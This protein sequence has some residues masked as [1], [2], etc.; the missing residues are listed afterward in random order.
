LTTQSASVTEP[1]E[2]VAAHVSP[3]AL[4]SRL[5]GGMIWLAATKVLG[6][7]INWIITI[8][9]LR[10]LSPQ[11]YGLMGLA[12]LFT[13]F[14]LL[15][16]EF[17]FG[18]AIV[19]DAKLDGRQ[20]ANLRYAIFL[21]NFTLFVLTLLG[22]PLVA[23]YFNEPS[24]VA[25]VRALSAMFVIN[26]VGA[27]SMFMLQREMAFRKK[28]QAEIV[29]SLAGGVMTLLGAL[30]GFGVWSLVIGYLLQQLAT[31]ALYVVYCPLAIDFNVSLR[32]VRR[33]VNFGLQVA[34][35]R[36]L[37]YGSSNADFMVVGRLL[38]TTQ[39]GF[40][41]MAF[42]FS[43]LPIEK[44][45]S[46]VTQVAFP[47]FSALQEDPERLRHY[48]LKLVASVAFVTF[49]MF[50]GLFLVADVGVRLFLTAKWV[51]VIVP[52]K[53]L[54]VVSCLR[55][56]E[57]LNAPL[58]L[59]TARPRIILWNNLL[60]V[61][62]MPIGF[63]LGTRYGLEGVSYAWLITWPV[64]F[65]IVTWQTLNV[66]GLTPTDYIAGLRHCLAGSMLMVV[67]VTATQR[68]VFAGLTPLVQVVGTC[69]L[70]FSLYLAYIGVFNRSAINDAMAIVKRR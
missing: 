25:I 29:G 41:T 49:P 16:N 37:W 69:G 39:L 20:L 4:K 36:L 22:A 65:A 10:L 19:Q 51:P 2:R 14:L 18:A 5:I 3:V 6:Q 33:F 12:I 24:L 30:A 13:G 21:I 8:A 60:Q 57:T 28:S 27:P 17:G 66:I 26:G 43:S 23:R 42:Q 59:A 38:G 34:V 62:V 1:T 52:L 58:L 32:H 9:V 56:I 46:L 68:Y 61:V 40:Y 47:S 44:I 54:C 64:L 67:G 7:S 63:Y 15:F 35:G 31:N 11:D 48:Y 70:G 55:A 50:L 45:V 53:I